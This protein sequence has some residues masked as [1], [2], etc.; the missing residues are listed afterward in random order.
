MCETYTTLEP[1]DPLFI[2]GGAGELA[3]LLVLTFCYMLS[4]LGGL[5][6]ISY[7]PRGRLD[8]DRAFTTTLGYGQVLTG[9]MHEGTC[10]ST[11]S[12]TRVLRDGQSL[13]LTLSTD[14]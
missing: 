6:L 3:Q 12:R 9:Q 10:G 13:T 7:K 2:R 11:Q 5:H 4:P 14:C 1:E 8:A